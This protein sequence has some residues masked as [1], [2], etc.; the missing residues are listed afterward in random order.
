MN[1][2]QC[3]NKY[4]C[5]YKNMLNTHEKYNIIVNDKKGFKTRAKNNWKTRK[6][7][8]I[9]NNAKPYA[10]LM[11]LQICIFCAELTSAE[12]EWN[13]SERGKSVKYG[14][15]RHLI[16]GKYSQIFLTGLNGQSVIEIHCEKRFFKDLNSSCGETFFFWALLQVSVCQS[17][18]ILRERSG[19]EN[20]MQ[21]QGRSWSG[22][23]NE[24]YCEDYFA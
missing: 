23:A 10:N 21:V 16:E 14:K 24:C 19:R 17:P 6:M 11:L 4:I 12:W 8:R 7:R 5:L 2:C 13:K 22:N 20:V 9:P 1:T 3:L 18:A 15:T